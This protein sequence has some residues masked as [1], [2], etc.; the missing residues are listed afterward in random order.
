MCL[1]GITE[2][3]IAFRIFGNPTLDILKRSYN[4]RHVISLSGLIVPL[5]AGISGN[6]H[7]DLPILILYHPIPMGQSLQ[8]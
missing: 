7:Q 5:K 1:E 6:A 3:R 2:C 8:Q 4:C